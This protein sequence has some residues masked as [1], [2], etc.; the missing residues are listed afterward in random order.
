[1]EDKPSGLNV[2]ALDSIEGYLRTEPVSSEAIRIAGGPLQYWELQRSSGVRARL[3]K[4]A[5]DYLSA[6]GMYPIAL[7]SIVYLCISTHWLE[8]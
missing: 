1:M 3:A 5:I 7:G 6:P 8:I 2:P 4:F